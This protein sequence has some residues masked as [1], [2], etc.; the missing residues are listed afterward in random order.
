MSTA[1]K[2]KR[3]LLAAIAAL[4]P[5]ILIA[6]GAQAQVPERL[7][8]CASAP[9]LGFVQMS[10]PEVG[11]VDPMGEP[12]LEFS[13][14]AEEIILGPWPN[15]QTI[16]MQ[17][18]DD[19]L[20]LAPEVST[21]TMGLGSDTLTLC[22][23]RG[24]V[25]TVDVGALFASNAQDADTVIIGADVLRDA[26][27]GFHREIQIF[28]LQRPLDKVIVEVP[29]GWDSGTRPDNTGLVLQFG[30]VRISLAVDLNAPFDPA[31]MELFEL[32]AEGSVSSPIM[33]LVGGSEALSTET[34]APEVLD[35]NTANLTRGGV[36]C[37]ATA[38][39]G[40]SEAYGQPLCTQPGQSDCLPADPSAAAVFVLGAEAGQTRPFGYEVWFGNGHSCALRGDLTRDDAATWTY[41]DPT[42]ALR[43]DLTDLGAALVST[44]VNPCETSCGARA[45]GMGGIQ[46]GWEDSAVSR[47]DP[48]LALRLEDACAPGAAL[49]DMPEMPPVSS[50]PGTLDTAESDFDPDAHSLP[51]EV[52][53][54]LR[55][56]R[57]L[58]T[59]G[60]EVYV[61][62]GAFGPRSR[63][64][65]AAFLADQGAP[66]DGTLT[67][68]AGEMLEA[69]LAGRGV[70]PRPDDPEA[71]LRQIYASPEGQWVFAFTRRVDW[72][73]AD[74][75]D[76]IAW[77]ELRYSRKFGVDG[78]D[79]NPV[80]PGNEW[81]V[82]NLEVQVEGPANASTADLSVRFDN[83]GQPVLL[84]YA[85]RGEG[86]VWRIHDILSGQGSL[87]AMLN[88]ME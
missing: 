36:F 72:F 51:P 77:A 60:Y 10:G 32:R 53:A 35:M 50:D 27:Q 15:G 9:E 44:G 42:C 46:G 79:F 52:A 38:H 24:L 34:S 75:L 12:W 65:L 69:A 18:G 45:G 59:L 20:W 7:D 73:T 19:H 30:D 37:A 3:H 87:R 47:P 16:D 55:A 78:F 22:R 70:P 80:M 6:S 5:A 63:A 11:P 66:G 41:S 2:Q 23:M 48:T 86:G 81:S 1:K 14:E 21:V 67:A 31:N 8:L 4:L 39:S 26:P 83:F 61:L 33:E 57:I 13:D 58:N 49:S 25:L 40:F 71:M 54:P 74:T 17:G 64:A 76:L 88:A 82:E 84:T 85:L 29:E 28:G 62:D 68:E 43:L 56:Q